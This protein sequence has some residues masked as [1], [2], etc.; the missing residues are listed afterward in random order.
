MARRPRSRNAIGPETILKP[1]KL[2]GAQGEAMFLRRTR[3]QFDPA[4]ADEVAALAR[5]LKALLGRL[6]GIQHAH[7]A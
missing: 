7:S 5:E 4:K 2:C 6:P 1:I 3:A